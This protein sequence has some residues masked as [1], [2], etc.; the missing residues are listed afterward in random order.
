M[1]II[2]QRFGQLGNRLLLFAHLIAFAQEHHLTVVNLAFE[3]YAP[4]FQA[5]RGDL[6]CRYPPARSRLK[7]TAR[8]RHWLFRLAA[9]ALREAEARHLP[10]VRAC[11][12]ADDQTLLLDAEFARLA[13][14]KIVFVGGWLFRMPGPLADSAPA[15]RDYFR[16]LDESAQAAAR[17]ARSARDGCDV[18]MGVHVRHG[19]YRGYAGGR[20]FFTP[21][22]YAALMA[23][24]ASLFP[25]QRV[26]FLICS[27]ESQPAAPF[28]GLRVTFGP[29]DLIEDLYALAACD[30]LLGPPSTFTW[31]ASFYGGV[32]LCQIQAADAAFTREDFKVH[33][34]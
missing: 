15:L 2:A 25:A 16:P 9:R 10:F 7:P 13:R 29:G 11:R 8:R 27:N 3:E 32:P 31:W 12:L 18:L 22:Q 17:S 28:E 4:L 26:G 34:G 20:Y 33:P 21:E 23:R 19:D 5:T 30:F 14:R 1:I 6:F 24:A